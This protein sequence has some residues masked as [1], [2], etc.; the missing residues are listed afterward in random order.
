MRAQQKAQRCVRIGVPMWWWI[1]RPQAEEGL[2]GGSLNF[3]VVKVWF[4]EF[5]LLDT[6]TGIV[7][8]IVTISLTFQVIM[9]HVSGGKGSTLPLPWSMGIYPPCVYFRVV[10]EQ[11]GQCRR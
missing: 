6:C 8:C 2:E 4:A 10:H 7:N 11:R 1:R 9:V 5:R 3:M